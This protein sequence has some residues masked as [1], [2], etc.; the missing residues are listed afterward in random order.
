MS[1]EG[2]IPVW[3]PAGITSHDCVY[4]MRKIA[5]TKKVGHTGTLDPA[6]EGVLP[7]CIER[8]TKI[9]DYMMDLPKS[10]RCVVALGSST[11]TED[12]EGEQVETLDPGEFSQKEIEDTLEQFTGELVQIPPMYSAVKVNGRKLY[13]YAREGK[14]VERPSKK[15]TIYSITLNE[16]SLSYDNGIFTF[17]CDIV[18]SKGTYIRT[19]AVD[20]GRA[21]SVPAHM[22]SLVRTG[23]GP[24]R[25]QDSWTLESLAQLQEE[26]ML[27]TA[28]I[29]ITDALAHI[30]RREAAADELALIKNGAVL[31]YKEDMPSLFIYMS[32]STPLAVYE[33]HPSKPD[34]IKPKT[35]LYIEAG[36]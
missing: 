18:C 3:K 6:V 4:K 12:A 32:G 34:K 13:E 5:R 25:E 9:S 36:S 19:L 20:I 33:R 27:E 14:S 29:P 26:S 30:D 16:D 11:T 28:V 10:Y 2:I 7:I 17:E 23:S 8:A 1:I 22:Q 24:F 15:I 31:S 21:L 35:M